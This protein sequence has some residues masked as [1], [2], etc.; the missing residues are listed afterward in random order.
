R[1]AAD[2]SSY[3]TSIVHTPGGPVSALTFGNGLTLSN[4]FTRRYAP[5]A[6]S[7]GP[8]TLQYGMTAAGD[9]A[10]LTEDATTTH[11][12]QYDF[13]GRLATSPGW[14]SYGYDNNG[15]RSSESLQSAS[16]TYTYNY[17]R[18]ARRLGSTGLPEYGYSVDM[19]GHTNG[20]AAFNAS[21]TQLTGAMC[22]THD[23]FGRLTS[24]GTL[25]QSAW[26]PDYF[27][28]TSA[29]GY[30]CFSG[31]STVTAQFKYDSRNRRI[32]RRTSAGQWAYVISDA[33]GNPLSEIAKT[34]DPANPWTKVRDYVWLDGT[35]LAQIEYPG[36]SGVSAGYV[37]Y[38]HADNLGLPRALTNQAAQT[39][40][41]AS[42]QPFGNVVETTGPDPLSGRTVVTNLRLPGQYDERLL[43]SLGLQGPYY[44]WNRWYLPSVG[45]YLEL[46]PIA[47]GG[48]FNGS[49][50]HAPDWYN[51]AEGNPLRW[52]DPDGTAPETSRDKAWCVAKVGCK[53]YVYCGGTKL[54][55]VS[56]GRGTEC[57]FCPA[58]L[59]PLNQ[60][61]WCAYADTK[62]SCGGKTAA[63]FKQQIMGIP[64]P[65]F[66]P[67]C[68]S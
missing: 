1:N 48:G 16:K 26:S 28:G 49:G 63:M 20:V 15:N 62:S 43:G 47:L 67:F 56:C 23:A 54:D 5:G 4:T 2:G 27:N 68:F 17:D 58:D 41:T 51:Y 59:K 21:G 8:L 12:F 57:P 65:W 25:A 34:G 11:A 37:Y 38:Y 61:D 33:G 39:V 14:L 46:D 45:R 55:L 64:T 32:A 24:L 9:V 50:W 3:A 29:W 42:V 36:P 30:G 13:V 7:S 52:T 44:N 22:W 6:L 10:S 40:W 18:L 60:G 19:Q 53:R 66:G 31:P 35:P